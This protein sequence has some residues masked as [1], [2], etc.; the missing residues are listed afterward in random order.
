MFRID[1]TDASRK[2][3]KKV[4]WFLLRS[5]RHFGASVEEAVARAEMRET[6]IRRQI[7]RLAANPFRGT[8]ELRYGP[9][10]RYINLD[11]A[12]VWFD[13]DE[14]RE[15]LQILAVFFEGQDHLA[16]MRRRLDDGAD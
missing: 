2:D 9:T 1:W 8:L 13:V 10:I 5:Y 11:R 12:I 15:R 6:E 16:R 3:L 14:D 4:Y 7:G